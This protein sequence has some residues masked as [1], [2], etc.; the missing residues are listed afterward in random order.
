[1]RL[2]TAREG[3]TSPARIG[4]EPQLAAPQVLFVHLED[5]DLTSFAIVRSLNPRDCIFRM[6]SGVT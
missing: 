5:L 1:M 2:F 4:G 3:T 6:N